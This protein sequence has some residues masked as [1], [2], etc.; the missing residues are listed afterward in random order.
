MDDVTLHAIV[1]KIQ[2]QQG[3]SFRDLSPQE[4]NHIVTLMSEKIYYDNETIL[5]ENESG[6]SLFYILDGSVLVKKKGYDLAEISA[7]NCFGEINFLKISPQR[8]AT[9]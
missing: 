7:G 2:K 9:V 8:T 1:H 5:K 4:I 3:S 6:S